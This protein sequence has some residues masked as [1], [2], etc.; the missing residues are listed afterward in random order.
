MNQNKNNLDQITEFG[1]EL[2]T[3]DDTDDILE[4]ISSQAKSLVNAQRCS[5][6]VVDKENVTLWTKLNDGAQMIVIPIDSGIVGQTYKTQEAQIVNAPY[7]NPKFMSKIDEK[8]GYSTKNIITVPVFDSK[9]ELIS[10][11]ELLNK[12]DSDFNEKDLEILT[13]FANFISG[14]LELSLMS[15]WFES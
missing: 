13:F 5:I 6:F 3:L 1:I 11:I 9:K 4:L 2:M 8:I 7:D 10:I 15:D 12:V 14:S